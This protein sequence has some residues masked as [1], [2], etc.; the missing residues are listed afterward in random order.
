MQFTY[1]CRKCWEKLWAFLVFQKCIKDAQKKFRIYAKANLENSRDSYELNEVE[2]QTAQIETTPIPAESEKRLH[3]TTPGDDLSERDLPNV[4]TTDV[5][6]IDDTE[7]EEAGEN[8]FILNHKTGILEEAESAQKRSKIKSVAANINYADSNQGEQ[9]VEKASHGSWKLTHGTELI[10][11][12][13]SSAQFTF[14]SQKDFERLSADDNSTTNC[15]VHE[16]MNNCIIVKEEVDLI[17]VNGKFQ[18]IWLDEMPSGSNNNYHKIPQHIEDIVDS[19]EIKEEAKEIWIEEISS[20]TYTNFPQISKNLEGIE[21]SEIAAEIKE[22]IAILSEDSD[23]N[24]S[25]PSAIL[26]CSDKQER[27][28][29]YSEDSCEEFISTSEEFLPK[30]KRL[31][32]DTSLLRPYSPSTC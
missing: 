20:E 11:A 21:N 5:I 15:E 29:Q 4:S 13:V 25:S 8:G 9:N 2:H 14:S 28:F 22:T 27:Y 17:D 10:E 24:I 23:D 18:E 12:S 16:F 6:S 1:I 3:K 31:K 32:V 30:V 19:S 7:L 26:S